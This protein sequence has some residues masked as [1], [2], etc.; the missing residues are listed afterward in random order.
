MSLD[1]IRKHIREAACLEE[2]LGWWQAGLDLLAREQ[3]ERAEKAGIL[4]PNP[5][6]PNA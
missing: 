2:M 5:Q 1:D 3:A 6:K 4:I